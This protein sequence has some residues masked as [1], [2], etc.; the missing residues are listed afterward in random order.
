[1][2]EGIGNITQW[3]GD[4]TP[5][6]NPTLTTLMKFWEAASGGIGDSP[7]DEWGNNI[8]T[9][10]AANVGGWEKTKE[11]L[12]WGIKETGATNLFNYDPEAKTMLEIATTSVPILNRIIKVSNRGE[13]E[14]DMREQKAIDKARSEVR[15]EM[16]QDVRD[17]L[18]EYNKLINLGPRRTEAQTE[19]LGMIENDEGIVAPIEDVIGT[20]RYWHRGYK[21]WEEYIIN[22]RDHGIEIDLK[23]IHKNL[24]RD[25]Q[26]YINKK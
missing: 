9:R 18:S 6:L 23:G 1:M 7:R 2:P 10:D 3:T 12:Y 24:E 26:H 21:S 8:L 17:L 20:L 19:R 5:N 11:M 16:P 13:I 4:Q 15:I 14:A 25:A 22:S